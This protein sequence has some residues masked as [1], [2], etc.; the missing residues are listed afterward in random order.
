MAG[1]AWWETRDLPST[2]DFR[3]H[4]W[5]HFTPK[6]HYTWVP[7]WAISPKLQAAVVVWEDPMFYRHH[8]INF[9]ELG[10]A[11]AD[12]VRAGGYRRGGS[13]ITQQVA[14]NLF[15]TPEKSL[16]RKFREAVIAYRLE[17]AFTKDEILEIYLNVA[18][19][20][21]GVAGAEAASQFYFSKSA[22][23]LTWADAALLAALLPNPV[24]FNPIENPEQAIVRRQTVLRKLM[25]NGDIK[26]GE[27]RQAG[28]T[29]WRG[30]SS[31]YLHEVAVGRPGS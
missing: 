25:E 7:L 2:A 11:L 19:W 23:E 3:A 18:E 8:G 5:D 26:E 20:G 17:H 28:A 16:R 9:S 21:D 4:L 12:D 24:H 14:K 13:T 1:A 30:H 6:G 22:E 15:L 27:F 31:P 29:S 10:R